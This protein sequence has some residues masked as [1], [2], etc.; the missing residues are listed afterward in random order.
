VRIDTA[1]NREMMAIADAGRNRVPWRRLVRETMQIAGPY[2]EF[3]QHTER[4]WASVTFSGARHK[5]RLCFTGLE[6][7]DAADDFIAAL[8]DHEFTIPGWLAA[9]AAIISV[10]QQALPEPKA[11]V[12]VEVLLLE[13][14]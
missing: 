5:V 12:E 2:A 9:D 14:A 4:S 1:G 10:D 3:L 6:A 8:P 13:D 7:M 11:T